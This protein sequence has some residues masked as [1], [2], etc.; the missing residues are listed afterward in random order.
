MAYRARGGHSC[1]SSA[2]VDLSL[3]CDRNRQ[4]ADGRGG[5]GDLSGT[6]RVEVDTGKPRRESKATGWLDGEV[7]YY[8][9]NPQCTLQ[10]R[11]K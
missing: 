7:L 6:R 8:A 10:M 4:R 9:R 2:P 1:H 11:D 5:A 3:A